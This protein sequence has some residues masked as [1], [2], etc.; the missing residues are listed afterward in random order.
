MKSLQV[1][2]I[3]KMNNQQC[4]CE[5]ETDDSYFLVFVPPVF[6]SASLFLF[7]SCVLSFG[8]G[9]LFQIQSERIMSPFSRT[10]SYPGSEISG[11]GYLGSHILQFGL[12]SLNISDVI[13][14]DHNDTSD[15]LPR[16]LFIVNCIT[17]IAQNQSWNDTRT[18][19]LGEA[20]RG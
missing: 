20:D 9:I 10:S 18:N 11:E 4:T 2:I 12:S 8:L 14:G 3:R 13:L 6:P 17:T 1:S 16:P 7:S 15:Q 19:R 5:G